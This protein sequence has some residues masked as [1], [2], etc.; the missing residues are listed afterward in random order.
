M[1]GVNKEVDQELLAIN[2]NGNNAD[3][4]TWVVFTPLWYGTL[5]EEDITL[6]TCR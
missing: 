3:Q 6:L 2:L 4:V 5:D 1:D